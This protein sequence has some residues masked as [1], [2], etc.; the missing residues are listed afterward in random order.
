MLAVVLKLS[1][2][3]ASMGMSASPQTKH[4]VR[5]RLIRETVSKSQQRVHYATGLL[6]VARGKNTHA[7][8]DNQRLHIKYTY[9][10]DVDG[11]S[12]EFCVG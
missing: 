7:R 1:S 2:I 10:H 5:T 9:I 8:S 3:A 4:A 6:A 11:D 12:V